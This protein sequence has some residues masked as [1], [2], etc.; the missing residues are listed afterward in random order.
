MPAAALELAEDR[1]ERA[2]ELLAPVIDRSARTLHPTWAAIHALL[3]EAAARE[4]LGETRAVEA[5]IERALELAEPEG[6]ILPFTIT[7][8]QGLLERHAR[9]STAHPTLLAET[10]DVLG[11]V[12]PKPRGGPALPV[13]ELSEAELRV[14]RYLP[15]NLKAPEIAAE[16]FVST[17]TVRTHL[18]HIYAK[19]GAHGRAE[20]VARARELRLLG[21]TSR[22]R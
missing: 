6:L 18:R 17:N 5:A 22:P 13:E 10:L 11:G 2:L 16:L 12:T 14:V 4:Q 8:V 15:T 19:L 21:P 9:G 1:P 3:F 7:P 20:A